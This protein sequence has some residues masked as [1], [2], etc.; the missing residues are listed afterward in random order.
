MFC[1]NCLSNGAEEN[2]C[3]VCRAPCTL[4]KLV[5]DMNSDIQDYFT[6]PE[7]LLK[8]SCDIIQ[9]QRR[10][11]HRLLSYLLQAN[12]FRHSAFPFRPAAIS[13]PASFRPPPP[14]SGPQKAPP[15]ANDQV[16]HVTQDIIDGNDA[17]HSRVSRVQQF[18]KAS[19]TV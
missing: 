16:K 11:R 7:E 9:F 14:T 15:T 18:F 10:H 1:T 12:K 8:K 5:P 19:L 13:L 6:E 2:A 3:L 17:S 4:M